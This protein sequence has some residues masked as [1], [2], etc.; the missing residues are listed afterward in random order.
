MYFS[1]T[2]K[3]SVGPKITIHCVGTALSTTITAPCTASPQPFTWPG[4]EDPDGFQDV[5]GNR[6]VTYKVDG[7]V[8]G[9]G[10][11][12]GN[13]SYPQHSRP[14][15]LQK[16]AS[17]GFTRSMGECIFW[18]KIIAMVR[19]SRLRVSPES[20]ENTLSPSARIVTTRPSTTHRLRCQ[21]WLMG[22]I[23]NVGLCCW[24]AIC[25]D[26][27]LLEVRMC[28]QMVDFSHSMLAM[29]TC[30]YVY[31]A[32]EFRWKGGAGLCE[33][34]AMCTCSLIDWTMRCWPWWMRMSRR[35]GARQK[36]R[37]KNLSDIAANS[38]FLSLFFSNFNK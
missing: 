26:G 18:I 16:V 5:D 27:R 4:T 9:N 35:G 14:L 19:W 1:A 33:Q 15:M 28:R 25:E 21:I 10:G 34:W 22:R 24:Q 32:T 2:L 23:L 31:R 36:E 12:C 13:T 17:D 29:L 38:F 6:Y 11:I 30:D 20:E 3:G 7:N 8:K 37:I